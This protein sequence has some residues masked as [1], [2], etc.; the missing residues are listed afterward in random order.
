MFDRTA[1]AGIRWTTTPSSSETP[2]GAPIAEVATTTLQS[3]RRRSPTQISRQYRSAPPMMR[4][5]VRRGDDDLQTRR[6]LLRR[7]PR[8]TSRL[9]RLTGRKLHIVPLG[10][11]YGPGAR[12]VRLVPHPTSGRGA[13]RRRWSRRPGRLDSAL[14]T[15]DQRTAKTRRPGGVPS[16]PRTDTAT[17]METS[18]KSPGPAEEVE[19]RSGAWAQR[20][21]LVTGGASFIGSHLVEA[22]VKRGAR[23][24]VVDNLSSGLFENIRSHG[25][26]RDRSSSATRICSTP[27]L[28]AAPPRAWRS[29]FTWPPITEGAATSTRTRSNVRRT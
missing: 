16:S 26:E 15:V 11:K 22:L 19:R 20:N 8:S 12:V 17:T 1:R 4:R 18:P 21:V 7:R 3:C 27:R 5:V 6:P 23:V 28:P 29:S 9:R 14:S 24:R 25:R 13:V 2:G 10:L